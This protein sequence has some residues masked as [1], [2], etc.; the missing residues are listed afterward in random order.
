MLRVC[1]GIIK[2]GSSSDDSKLLYEYVFL[3]WNSIFSKHTTHKRPIYNTQIYQGKEKPA[4][5]DKMQFERSLLVQPGC[6]WLQLQ[7]ISSILKTVSELI[8]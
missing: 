4:H 6:T 2:T 3:T 8:D 5:A 1:N 7:H